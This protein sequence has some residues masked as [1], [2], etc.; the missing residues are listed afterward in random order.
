MLLRGRSDFLLSHPLTTRLIPSS[1]FSFLPSPRKLLRK[2]T[3]VRSSGTVFVT[4]C[5]APPR[6]NQSGESRQT[7]Q[8]ALRHEEVGS[9]ALLV[10]HEFSPWHEN[11][12]IASVL[13]LNR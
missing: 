8:H 12:L 4:R 13:G 5:V 6:T 11:E 9:S 1:F 7:S 3:C 2:A 10:T